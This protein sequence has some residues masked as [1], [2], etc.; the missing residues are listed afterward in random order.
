MGQYK[1]D[2][3]NKKWVQTHAST[4]LGSTKIQMKIDGL[5]GAGNLRRGMNTRVTFAKDSSVSH[6][7]LAGYLF[8]NVDIV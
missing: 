3:S 5:A 2:V 6:C 1:S 7:V 4:N 8:S